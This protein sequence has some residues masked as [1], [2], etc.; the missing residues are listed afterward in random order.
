M[1]SPSSSWQS[2]TVLA[3][4][5]N[6]HYSRTGGTDKPPLVM[7]HGFSDNGLC[8]TPV[9]EALA[10]DYDVILPDARHHGQS[11]SPDQT[12]SMIDLA[13]DLAGLITALNL[14]Q[15]I[16]LGHSMGA[17]TTLIMAGRYPQ[18]PA[19][20]LL[21]DPPPWWMADSEPPFDP[22]WAVPARQGLVAQQ[23]QSREAL[24][25]ARHAESPTWAEAELGPWAD[26]KLSLSLNALDKVSA[27]PINWPALLE[28]VAC[29]VLLITADPSLKSAV[30]PQQATAL[31][32]LVPQTQIAHILGT[33]HNIRREQFTAYMAAVRSFLAV[34]VPQV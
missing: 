27:P 13:D 1:T 32:A 24:M 20:I 16:V 25:A 2:A 11:A 7:A 21:E 19:A 10:A 6:F 9:A 14:Q 5:L 15:P 34:A 4:G 30:T 18:L 29:P 12:F 17:I 31:Q 8:W 28:Q 33:G 26:S 3:N 23:T 22:K